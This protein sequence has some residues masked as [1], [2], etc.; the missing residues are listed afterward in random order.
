[1]KA[2]APAG[3]RIDGF[4]KEPMGVGCYASLSYVQGIMGKDAFNLVLVKCSPADAG[5][6]AAKLR[7]MP[8]VAKVE[9]KGDTIAAMSD[10]I[11]GAIRPMFNIVLVMVLAIGFA[12]VFTL[13]T[14]MFLER[15]QEIATARTLGCSP[16]SVLRGFLLEMLL[17]GLIA[18]PAGVLLGW[19]LCWVL[20]NKVL[21]ASTTQLA[22]E[23]SFA[24][25][26][27]ALL[28]AAFLAVIALSVLPSF[29]RISRIDLA[30]AARERAG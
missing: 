12:I 17:A 26:P 6:I 9:V 2:R 30:G 24:W 21:S 16:S 11:N 3:F 7:R 20:M 10:A 27:V 5:G 4:V 13:T 19:G 23:M 28:C 22:P 25:L 29:R 14:I 15:R 18:L 8:G 1:M